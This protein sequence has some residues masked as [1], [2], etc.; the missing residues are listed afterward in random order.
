[1]MILETGVLGH[2]VPLPDSILDMKAE[3]AMVVVVA[4]MVVVGATVVV[5][6]RKSTTREYRRARRA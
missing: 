6:A 5:V 4:A 1:M 3:A 2:L